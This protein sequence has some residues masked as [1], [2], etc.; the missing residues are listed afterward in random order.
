[1]GTNSFY[2]LF[3]HLV[4]YSS[5]P[6]ELSGQGTLK[7]EGVVNRPVEFRKLGGM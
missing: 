6:R 3:R 5:T 1:V 7:T 2:K 4:K